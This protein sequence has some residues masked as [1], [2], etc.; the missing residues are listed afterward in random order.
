MLFKTGIRRVTGLLLSTALIFGNIA[1]SMTAYAVDAQ[2]PVNP[3]GTTPNGNKPQDTINTEGTYINDTP[4][5]LQVSKVKTE[6]GGHEGIAPD[7]TDAPQKN[8]VTYKISGRVE[9]AAADLLRDYGADHIELA[10]S[11]NN[12][13]LGYGWLKGTLEYLMNRKAQGLN[14]TMQIMYNAQGVFEGYAYVTRTLETADD[15]NR[16]VAGAEMALYDAVEIFRNPEVTRDGEYYGEDDRFTGVTVV[17]DSGSNNVTSVYV[18]KGHA[19]NQT[20]YVL[21]KEDGSKVEID[22]TGKVVDDN[23]NYQDEINDSGDGVWIAK[24]IEREDTP[25]LFYSLDNLH[26]TSNDEYTSIGLTNTS[27][28]DE[29]YGAE[30]YNKA[31]A[32]YGFDKDGNVVNIDQKDERDFSIYAYEAGSARPVYEFVGGDFNEIRYSLPNKTIRVGK[33]TVM[34][35][36]DEDGNRDAMVDPQTGIAYIEEKIEPQAGHDN[37]HDVN[38]TDSTENTKLFVWPV[39]VFYDGS[40]ASQGNQSGSRTFQKILTTR[41]ATINADTAQCCGQ[42]FL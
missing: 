31:N 17:R 12:A 14:E 26:V 10:Y 33:D 2:R 23:Y 18:N 41:I 32:L 15:A 42:A 28:V 25:I 27:K 35:H 34:Y 36:L 37:I 1:P 19:G 8:T 29:V 16:Y 4:A 11:S 3:D 30:R 7:K 20:M 22:S 9:G 38:D 40:G 21:Q 5:R 6:V 39:N 24:T 13:Y